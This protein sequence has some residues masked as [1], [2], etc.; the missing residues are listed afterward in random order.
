MY[1]SSNENGQKHQEYKSN[2][3]ISPHTFSSPR[4]REVTSRCIDQV[5]LEKTTT[6]NEFLAH[7]AEE[8]KCTDIQKPN[9]HIRSLCT[10]LLKKGL[11]DKE[12]I[13]AYVLV[14]SVYDNCLKTKR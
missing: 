7:L 4:F 8:K 2:E 9:I 11:Y 6:A 14:S 10:S 1:K 12:S 13:H 3:T 5:P